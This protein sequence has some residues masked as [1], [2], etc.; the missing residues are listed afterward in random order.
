MTVWK[1][2]KASHYPVIQYLW[3]DIK[4]TLGKKYNYT[5]EFKK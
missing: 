1:I 4:K 3:M 2:D 5:L